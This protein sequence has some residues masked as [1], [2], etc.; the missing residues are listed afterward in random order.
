MCGGGGMGGGAG[1]PFADVAQKFL[2]VPMTGAMGGP[3]GTQ[4]PEMQP[5][6]IGQPQFPWAAGVIP[7]NTPSP[8]SPMQSNP[9]MNR[10][11]KFGKGF[12]SGMQMAQMMQK[13]P[14]QGME[15]RPQMITNQDYGPG[16][17]TG[18]L[19]GDYMRNLTAY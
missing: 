6:D 13:P 7:A 9:M 4:A 5:P 17:L 12:Q 16:P 18:G 1:N 14:A 10:V 8:A 2:R 15:Y 3:Q 19:L 11:K